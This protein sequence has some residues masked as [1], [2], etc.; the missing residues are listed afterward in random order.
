MPENG[1][2]EHS[3]T[4]LALASYLVA[5]GHPLIGLVRNGWKCRFVFEA[6]EKLIRDELTFLSRQGSVEPL[7]FHEQVRLLKAMTQVER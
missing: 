7:A 6:C 1:D 2:R 3:I 4:D 5:K